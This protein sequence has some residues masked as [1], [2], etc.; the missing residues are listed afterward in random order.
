MTNSGLAVHLADLGMA[1]TEI[2]RDDLLMDLLQPITDTG[3]LQFKK[4]KQKR[5][6]QLTCIFQTSNIQ[7]FIYVLNFTYSS[8]VNLKKDIHPQEAA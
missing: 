2:K 5:A 3:D 1:V 4:Q 6:Q 7:V 8:S